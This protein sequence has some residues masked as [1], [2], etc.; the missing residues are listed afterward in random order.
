MELTNPAV[1][2]ALM[3]KHGKQF[4]KSLGPNFLTDAG[5]LN[6]IVEQSAIGQ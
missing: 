2:R 5:V 3:Q 1:I 6:T 4:A